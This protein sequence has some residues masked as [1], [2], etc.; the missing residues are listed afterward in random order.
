MKSGY[1]VL[2]LGQCIGFLAVTLANI[3]WIIACV[4]VAA[5]AQSLAGFGFGLLAVPMMQ[6]ALSPRD[7]VIISTLIGAVSTTTQAVIDRKTAHVPTVKR[8]TIASYLGMPIG[9]MVFVLVSDSALRI[10]LGVVV[11][12]AAIVLSR[13]FTL[14]DDAH[15]FDW[16][17]GMV[18]GVL[19]TSTSTNGPP[20]VFLMQARKMS[21]EVFRSTINSIFSFANIGALTLFFVSG[22]MDLHTMY[23]ALAAIPALFVSL[24]LGYSLRPRV[25]AEFFRKLVLIMLVLSGA[26][27]L[28]KAML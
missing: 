16:L 25:S 5:F 6:M 19:A 13:G 1:G 11:I 3:M 7:A 4:G 8:L 22:K 27:L 9:L 15:H 2:T 12:L 24:R 17:L 18:S 10:T 26:S 20:L 23:G 14:H 21:P 28:L